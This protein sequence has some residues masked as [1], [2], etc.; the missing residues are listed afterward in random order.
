MKAI[1]MTPSILT[2]FSAHRAGLDRNGGLGFVA[3]LAM[4]TVPGTEPNGVR[5]N[6]E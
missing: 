5:K 2:R 3:S 1:S 6:D 4:F